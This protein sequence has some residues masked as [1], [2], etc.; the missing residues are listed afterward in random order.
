MDC[1][2][3]A[4]LL[5]S[6]KHV[7]ENFS[8]CDG[9]VLPLKGNEA[10]YSLIETKFGGDGK[11]TFQLPK[12]EAPQGMKYIICTRGIYPTPSDQ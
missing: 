10:L 4:I 7:P 2:I 5:F 8:L 6:G 3:G 1:L 11:T 12:M 9:K